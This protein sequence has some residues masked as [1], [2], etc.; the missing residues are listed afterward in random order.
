[1]RW[2][3]FWRTVQ[4][5]AKVGIGAVGT[6]VLVLGVNFKENCPD[7]CNSKVFDITEELTKYGCEVL[8]HDPYCDPKEAKAEYG[9]ELIKKVSEIPPVLAIVLAV[10]HKPFKQWSPT[11]WL[12]RLQAGGIVV[13]VK[14]VTP[15]KELVDAGV[16]ISRL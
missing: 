7:L 16:K 15:R 9:V 4:E 12:E 14:G 11:Q 3:Y 10:A 6:R 1:M 8:V 5:L 13:D 2:G